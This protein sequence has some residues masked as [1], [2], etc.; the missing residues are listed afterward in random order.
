MFMLF[1]RKLRNRV[2]TE[3]LFFDNK[4]KTYSKTHFFL[5]NLIVY[6]YSNQLDFKLKKR[7]FNFFKSVMSFSF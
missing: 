3:Y 6:L 2:L 1:N 4:L 5:I 7:K